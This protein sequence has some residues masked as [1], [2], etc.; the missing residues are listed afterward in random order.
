MNALVTTRILC[1]SGLVLLGACGGRSNT[2]RDVRAA[3]DSAVDLAR[4]T[5]VAYFVVTQAQ[6]DSDQGIATVLDDFQYSLDRAR[7]HLEH[8]GLQVVETYSDSIRL[9]WPDGR[10]RSFR[11]ADPDSSRVGYHFFKPGATPIS[12][13]NV[14]TDSDLFD[15]AKRYFGWQ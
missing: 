4:P 9:R 5:V 2:A 10:V 15:A 11:T 3:P 1:L 6:A 12:I 13:S 8:Q 14:L 7:S